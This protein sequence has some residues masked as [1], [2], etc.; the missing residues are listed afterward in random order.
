MVQ[1]SAALAALMAIQSKQLNERSA[2]PKGCYE[3][4]RNISGLKGNIKETIHCR[5]GKENEVDCYYINPERYIPQR[6]L[7]LYEK[8]TLKTF[9]IKSDYT[10]IVYDVNVVLYDIV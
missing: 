5:N 8:K 1:N 4:N 3:D 9:T 2:R 7:I 6:P 10:I